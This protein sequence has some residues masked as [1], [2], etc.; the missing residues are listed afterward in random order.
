[1]RSVIAALVSVL[2]AGAAYGADAQPYPNVDP[3]RFGW[4]GGYIG[5]GVGYGW[6]K[7]TDYQF[8][9]PLDDEGQDVIAG[10]HAGYNWQYGNF[11]VGGELEA[12][13]L[14]LTY[15]NFDFITIKHAIALK[16]R[17]GYAW[18]RYLITGHAGGVWASTNFMG[19]KDWGWV[20]GGGVDYALTDEITVGAQYSHYEW[21]EFD[22]T[23]IDATIDKVTAR[24]GLKF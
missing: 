8:T 9:P 17:A 2:A 19:L 12:L 15:E 3:I 20:A 7:D 1:M 21:K 5:L 16:A 4:D 14:D 13:N 10:I 23:L 11:V 6:L 22:G 18:D 24:V